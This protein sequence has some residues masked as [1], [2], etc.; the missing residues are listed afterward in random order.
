MFLF[1]LA[2]FSGVHSIAFA[3]EGGG[4]VGSEGGHGG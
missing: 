3:A 4:A 2:G 1:A